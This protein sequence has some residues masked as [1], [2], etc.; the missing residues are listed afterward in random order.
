MDILYDAATKF[1]ILEQFEYQFVISRRRKLQTIKLNFKN[2]DFFHIAGLQYLTD[3]IIPQDRAE[4]IKEIVINHSV[5]EQIISKSENFISKDSK[6]DVKSRIEELRFL[7]EYLNTE[8]F[9]KIFNINNQK[10]MSSV[11]RADYLIES[12]FKNISDIVYIFIRHREEDPEHYCIVSFFKKGEVAYS[13]DK[14]YFM[15]KVR[16]F[17]NS[18]QVIYA[19]PN[20]RKPS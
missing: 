7:E 11:I 17:G 14:V 1:L 10:G 18:E 6:K 3:I 12:W 16:R 19:N 15:E 9:I 13:G 20:Y 5:S 8:N 4:T 2:T